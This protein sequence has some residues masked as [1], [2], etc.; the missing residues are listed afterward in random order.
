MGHCHLLI[1]LLPS[2]PLHVS[3]IFIADFSFHLRARMGW[4][5]GI[6]YHFSFFLSTINLSLFDC[7]WQHKHLFH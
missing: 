6:F 7:F 1:T 2:A 3:L 5:F 4:T